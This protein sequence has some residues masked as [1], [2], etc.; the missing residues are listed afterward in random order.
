MCSLSLAVLLINGFP[1][2]TAGMC[3]S[4]ARLGT[5]V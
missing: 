4:D 1:Y 2:G 5:K 3:G